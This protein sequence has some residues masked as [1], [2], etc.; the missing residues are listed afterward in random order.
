MHTPTITPADTPTQVVT[1]T[2]STPWYVV[3]NSYS[4]T[5]LAA[6]IWR[7]ANGADEMVYVAQ[8]VPAKSPDLP[9]DIRVQLERV[10]ASLDGIMFP[11]SINAFRVSRSGTYLAWL[12]SYVWCRNPLEELDC[13]GFRFLKIVNA[14][15]FKTVF[16][17]RIDDA[18]LFDIAWSPSE[19]YIALRRNPVGLGRETDPQTPT[20]WLI[21]IIAGGMTELRPSFAASWCGREDSILNFSGQGIE[22][23]S[24]IPQG[25][26]IK[27]FP[28]VS[29]FSLQ[30]ISCSSISPVG[31]IAA[32]SREDAESRQRPVYLLNLELS[33]VSILLRGFGQYRAFESPQWSHDGELL[34]ANVAY[35]SD[36]KPTSTAIFTAGG[37]L[38]AEFPISSADPHQMSFVWSNSEAL[39]L[40]QVDTPNET[41]VEALDPILRVSSRLTIPKSVQQQID[42]YTH[43]IATAGW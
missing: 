9:A 2:V 5:P 19:R 40:R 11:V 3:L 30:S 31:V 18:D 38:V 23:I 36:D 32:Q 22:E 43:F 8:P 7:V 12:Q 21:D 24:G 34:A 10:S 4:Y 42:A 1:P 16:E 27:H 20:L 6:Q 28:A 26:A 35:T 25:D 41:L 17:K 29:F 33:T 39:V 13:I 37:E 15:S 14:S